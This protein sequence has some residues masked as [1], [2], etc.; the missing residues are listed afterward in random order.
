M[1]TF[2]TVMYGRNLC[3]SMDN[4]FYIL[5]PGNLCLMLNIDWFNPYDDTE[6][7]VGAIYLVVQNLPRSE[8]FKV[9]NIILIGL[10]PGPT[11]PSKTI[12]TYLELLVHDLLQLP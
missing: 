9:E 1:L 11:E 2:M 8:H 6:Y 7:S 3:I 12:N 10:I 5:C 4:H